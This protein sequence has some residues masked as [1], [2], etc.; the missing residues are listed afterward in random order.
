MKFPKHKNENGAGKVETA[1]RPSVAS[2]GRMSAAPEE[3]DLYS[4][5]RK[6]RDQLRRSGT[7]LGTPFY[8]ASNGAVRMHSCLCYKHLAPTELI[9]PLAAGIP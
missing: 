1:D 6:N 9:I 4:T 7:L 5:E 8:V 3:P 2:G